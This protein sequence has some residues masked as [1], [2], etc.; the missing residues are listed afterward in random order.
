MEKF[1]LI[2]REIGYTILII[3]FVVGGGFFFFK[4]KHPQKIEIPV[5]KQYVKLDQSKYQVVGDI[6]NAQNATQT[7][8]TTTSELDIYQTEVRYVQGSTNP[9]VAN[10]SQTDLPSEVVSSSNTSVSQSQTGATENGTA[11]SSEATE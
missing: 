8:E 4:D 3:A 5:A 11:E 9:F 10:N 6:Q 2:A 1:W 7:F